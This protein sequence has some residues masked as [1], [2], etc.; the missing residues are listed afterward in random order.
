MA[1]LYPY[2]LLTASLFL[3]AREGVPLLFF[4]FEVGFKEFGVL[5]V[6]LEIANDLGG[7]ET[8]GLVDC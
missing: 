1:N 6:P 4:G 2:F 7:A 3:V 5:E 8:T